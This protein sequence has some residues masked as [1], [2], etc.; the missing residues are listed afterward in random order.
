MRD[1][2]QWHR[3]IHIVDSTLWD[4]ARLFLLFILT[5]SIQPKL[6]RVDNKTCFI[7]GTS[8]TVSCLASYL[9]C[10]TIFSSVM[11]LAGNANVRHKLDCFLVANLLLV[12]LFLLSSSHLFYSTMTLGSHAKGACAMI[13]PT[14]RNF[15][16]LSLSES[17]LE[18]GA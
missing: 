8:G 17:P 10:N 5:L 13:S 1:R 9:V 7:S 16:I 11:A 6:K 2:A 14:W 18:L 12:P 3:K 15:S 4:K